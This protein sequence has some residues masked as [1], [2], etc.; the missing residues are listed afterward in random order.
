MAADIL[1][2]ALSLLALQRSS[3]LSS[4]VEEGSSNAVDVCCAGESQYK[5]GAAAMVGF[6]AAPGCC[7]GE[8]EGEHASSR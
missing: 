5:Y 2:N 3:E 8:G 4:A 1:R 7:H 6:A